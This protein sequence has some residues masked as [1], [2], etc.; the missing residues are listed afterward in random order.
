MIWSDKYDENNPIHARVDAALT[1]NDGDISLI[2]KE[3][4]EGNTELLDEVHRRM[5]QFYSALY[6]LTGYGFIQKEFNIC[7]KLDEKYLALIGNKK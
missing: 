4:E 2:K 5:R 1:W 7:E 6:L 3:I